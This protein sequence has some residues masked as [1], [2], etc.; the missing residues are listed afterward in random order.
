MNPALVVSFGVP[1]L[2]DADKPDG[3]GI[4]HETVGDS[5]IAIEVHT[6]QYRQQTKPP[7]VGGLTIAEAK[8]VAR[9]LER[10]IASAELAE[11]LRLRTRAGHKAIDEAATGRHEQHASAGRINS[12]PD[13]LLGRDANLSAG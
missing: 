6:F 3:V 1:R 8:A 7:T 12:I 11:E 9:L 4:H 2:L 13:H 5:A 10:A